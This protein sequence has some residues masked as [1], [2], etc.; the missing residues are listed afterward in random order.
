[1]EPFQKPRIIIVR[2]PH[3]PQRILANLLTYHGM[4][5]LSARYYRLTPC[6][7]EPIKNLTCMDWTVQDTS[8]N[9]SYFPRTCIL[10]IVAK[11]IR[12]CFTCRLNP[13]R[14]SPCVNYI[15]FCKFQDVRDWMKVYDP[16]YYGFLSYFDEKPSRLLAPWTQ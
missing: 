8:G 1:M 6:A 11:P 5:V 10:I 16:G 13:Y 14:G 3:N 9:L 2:N 4:E 15:P 7:F 12:Q